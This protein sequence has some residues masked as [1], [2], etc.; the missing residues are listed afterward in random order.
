MLVDDSAIIRELISRALTAI[1]G[2][3]IV[4][5][6]RNGVSA[7][8]L[9]GQQKPDIILLDIEM[10][11]MDGITALP[12]IRKLSPDSK[13]IMVSTLTIRNASLSLQALELGA[14]DYIAK[15]SAAIPEDMENFYQE[16]RRKVTALAGARKPLL[17]PAPQPVIAP[18]A[19]WPP[20]AQ[21]KA[22]AIASSTGGPQ[23]LQ[24]VFTGLRGRL[25]NIPIFVT[26][27]MPPTF[28]RLLA[29]H[30]AK[31]GE[32]PCA[33]GAEG[34]DAQPGH[35]Y[36]APGGYHMTATLDRGKT[37]LHLDQEPPVN[38][39]RPSADPMLMSLS[40]IYGRNLL[41]IVLT[42]MGQD[43]LDGAKE[44]VAAGGNVIAQDEATSA[45]WGMPK[46]VVTHNLCR[47]VLPL[48]NI[49]GYVLQH[50]LG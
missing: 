33:E 42:G 9:A 46:A 30:L 43:G 27:H 31:A 26:Q 45:V 16:L 1:P 35:A 47:A 22:L 34:D 10:P 5:T 19:A 18:S 41:T 39:C 2:L 8:P 12:A 24:E 3:E 36:I 23:A 20:M 17:T 49:A 21:V 37:M 11:E 13:I 15:P 38:F 32:R 40:K 7:I 14:S 48:P 4:A 28:T 50:V 29:E 25:K 44:V 6:A